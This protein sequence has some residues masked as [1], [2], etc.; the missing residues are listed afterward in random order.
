MVT[1]EAEK[2]ARPEPV[3]A[4]GTTGSVVAME[5]LPDPVFSEGM[6]GP[7]LGVRPESGVVYAPVC[8]IVSVAMPHAV[9]IISDTGVEVLIHIGVDTVKLGGR[10]FSTLVA[11]GQH[12]EA[13]EPLTVFDCEAVTAAGF[14]DI[15][16]TAVTN[17]D[18]LGGVTPSRLGRVAAGE[19]IN[20]GVAA[21]R[22]L[23]SRVVLAPARGAASLV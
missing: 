14:D 15:I 12:V 23:R 5:D 13:G 9:G 17:A 22:L 1:G 7:A 20:R 8:G 21:V 6:M 4:D 3:P 16:I 18:E 2:E 19:A 10:G 11:K